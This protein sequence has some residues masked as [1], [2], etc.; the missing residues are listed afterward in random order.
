MYL[1]ARA[2]HLRSRSKDDPEGVGEVTEYVL[3]GTVPTSNG[4]DGAVP[5]YLCSIRMVGERVCVPECQWGEGRC[6]GRSSGVRADADNPGEVEADPEEGIEE[7]RR[8]GNAVEWGTSLESIG[9]GP[10]RAGKATRT[11]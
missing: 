2:S 10:S 7:V 1:L 9:R 11:C 6:R 3:W 4:S 5:S 8:S